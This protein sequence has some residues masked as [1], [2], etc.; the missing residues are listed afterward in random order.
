MK[1]GSLVAA[2]GCTVSPG[3]STRES[4]RRHQGAAALLGSA[5]QSPSEATKSQNY[6]LQHLTIPISSFWKDH[7]NTHNQRKQRLP[8]GPENLGWYNEA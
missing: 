3:S 2:K 4:A 8:D 7:Q 5:E 1:T 6:Y